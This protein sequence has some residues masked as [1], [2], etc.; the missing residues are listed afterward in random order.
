MEIE[1]VGGLVVPVNDGVRLF[2]RY[3]GTLIRDG[4]VI[5]DWIDKNIVVN[6]G[7]NDWLSV[8]LAAGSQK[9]TWYLGLFSG[10]YTPLSTDT[11]ANIA[12]NSTES[13]AYSGGVRPTWSPGAVSGQAVDN[14]A[15]RATYTFTG[16]TTIY[17]GFLISN[18]TINGTS[19][20]LFSG[21][22]FGSAKSVVSGDQLLITYSLSTSSS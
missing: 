20:T 17:G 4:R 19:G 15:S 22:Q 2:G 12:S 16:T 21:A 7:L 3:H 11:A 18:N 5:E 10:N 1:K 14:S 6:Q 13:S 8:Y 9:T